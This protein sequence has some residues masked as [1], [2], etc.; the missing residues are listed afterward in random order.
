VI[1]PGQTRSTS[2]R[3]SIRRVFTLRVY[4]PDGG[5]DVTGGV[6][7]PQVTWEPTSDTGLPAVASPCRTLEKPSSS[8]LTDLY[9][10]LGGPPGGPPFP[11]R[12]RPVWRRFVN[13]CQSGADL[14]FDN[15][16]GDALP[17][18]GQNPCGAF[19]SGGFLSNIDNAYVYAFTSR[20][21]GPLLAFRGRAPTFADTY[22]NAPA[23][24]SGEQLRYWSFCQNDPLDQRYIACKRDDQTRVDRAG[25]YTLVIS[26]PSSWPAAAAR[27]CRKTVSWLP[28]GPQP[29][30]VVLYRQMLPAPT[31]TQA[32]QNVSHGSGQQQMGP[33]YPAGQYFSNWRAL[34]KTYCA[35]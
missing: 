17:L 9:A 10:A 33:Y 20:G 1:T 23:M 31:F 13:I 25:D 7:L 26:Q 6:G 14:L 34:A 18:A 15:A 8:T 4:V 19:G 27:R 28:W 11:G 29:E 24:P 16:I 35:A 5:R 3:A 30:G 32:I 22:P 21:F 12:N 2:I